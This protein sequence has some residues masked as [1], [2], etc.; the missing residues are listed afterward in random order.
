MLVND[1]EIRAVVGISEIEKQRIMDYLQGSVYCWC[2]HRESDWFAARDL[3]GGNN[4]DWSNTP[5]IVLYEKQM[6]L[7]KSESESVEQA[8]KELGWI[9]KRVL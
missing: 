6:D 4:H 9:L 3:V 7:G 8:G 5:L 2:N 1:H